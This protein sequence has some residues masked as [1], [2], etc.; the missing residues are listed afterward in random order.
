VLEQEDLRRRVRRFTPD[1]VAYSAMSAHIPKVKE[2]DAGL[3]ALAAAEG[4]RVYRIMGGPHATYSP[5]ILGE[6]GLNAICQGDGDRALPEWLSRLEDGA[7]LG[8]IPNIALTSEG[9]QQKE[10]VSD[11][12]SL[13][14][15][16]REAYYRCVPHLRRSGLHSFLATRG[17]PYACTYCFNHAYNK[18]FRGCGSVMRRR[19]VENVLD[20]IDQVRRSFSPLRMVRFADDAFTLKADPWLAEFCEKY[21]SRIGVPF[22]C[23]VRSDALTDEVAAMLA[24]AG[25]YSIGM[26]IEGGTEAIRNGILGR[27][28]SDDVV[29]RSFEVA[30]RHGL[31]TSTGN[32]IAVPGTTLADDW[33]LL[34]F[35]R[36]VGPTVPTFTIARPFRG[37]QLRHRAV[38]Q[39]LLDLDADVTSRYSDRSPLNCYTEREKRVQ[40]R[41]CYL[42]SMYCAAPRPLVPLVRRMINGPLPL[43]LARAVGFGYAIYRTATRIFPQGIPRTPRAIARTI[44]DGV[45]H[46]L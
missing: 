46:Y 19:S 7:D 13:P 36:R 15:A 14:F 10:L 27:N 30:R 38:N 32:I 31:N 20:E 37:T 22:Y 44:V 42:G 17:C 18:M 34:G 24:E 21:P 25:C 43:G 29:I 5:G 2:A 3:R 16:D 6:M 41:M 39:G 12:D 8:S 28:L 33:Q 35:T 26:S 1:V 9:A 40:A 45:R 23:C 4:K 11:L